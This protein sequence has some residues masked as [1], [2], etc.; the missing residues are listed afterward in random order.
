MGVQ[1]RKK[2]SRTVTKT[3]SLTSQE[4]ELLDRITRIWFGDRDR[5]S[6]QAV[7]RMIR[8]TARALGLDRDEGGEP[9]G[10]RETRQPPVES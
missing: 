4:E 1:K 8:D 3:F 9:G 10:E 2:E 6:S 5:V 7:G